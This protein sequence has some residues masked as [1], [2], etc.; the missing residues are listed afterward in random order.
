MAKSNW[1]NITNANSGGS[2]K[3]RHG[4]HDGVEAIIANTDIS[5]D[6]K[7]SSDIIS[8]RDTHDDSLSSV[9]TASSA[10]STCTVDKNVVT[11]ERCRRIKS[12][13][14]INKI[15]HLVVVVV[16]LTVTLPIDYL[17]NDNERQCIYNREKKEEEGR[18]V[19]TITTRS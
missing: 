17:V 6:D 19:T 7:L 12:V 16:V 11:R 4:F 15:E 14:V 9:N 8:A 2:I 13:N 10:A 5:A 3:S 1:H 18:N